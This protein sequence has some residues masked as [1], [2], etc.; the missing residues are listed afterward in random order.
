M[1]IKIQC[2]CGVKYA[3]DVGTDPVRF[4]CAQCGTDSSA[5]LNEIIRQQSGNRSQPAAPIC[6]RHSDQPA[7]GNCLI[8]KKPIC[9]QCMELFGYVCSAFCKGQAERAGLT[10]P[11]YENQKAVVERRFWKKVGRIAV[12]LVLLLAALAA[13]ALWYNFFGARPKVVFTVQLPDTRSDGFCKLVAADQVVVRHGN[14]LLRYDI[15]KK[16]EVW[17]VPLVEPKEIEQAAGE[18]ADAR[19]FEQE[20]ARARRARLKAE[21]KL[22]KAFEDLTDD[23]RSPSDAQAMADARKVIE[24]RRLAELRVHVNHSDI[25]V[26]YP[27]KVAHFGWQSGKIDKEIP[28][29]GRMERVVPGEDSLLVVS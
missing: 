24:E 26:V 23:D 27:D 1:T 13:A 22:S 19:K 17:S 3:L 15:G 4:V 12:A 7:T 6:F 16:K 9:P 29:A 18:W 2:P 28:F 25:W 20:T 11:V 21:G 14:H 8:C 10:L 5:A